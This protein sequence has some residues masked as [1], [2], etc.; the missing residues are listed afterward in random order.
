[1]KK[2]LIVVSALVFCCS[3]LVSCSDTN[4][5]QITASDIEKAELIVMPSAEN[6]RYKLVEESDY[7][8]ITELISKGPSKAVSNPEEIVGGDA[9]LYITLTDGT[10]HTLSNNGNVYIVLDGISYEMKD[11]FSSLWTEC[12]FN[13]GNAK[14]P[15]DFCY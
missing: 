9:T 14:A 2:L 8:K 10:V 4:K 11:D 15:D 6:E 3:L 1:M 12:G 7:G 13:V 5:L